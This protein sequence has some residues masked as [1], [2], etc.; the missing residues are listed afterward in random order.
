MVPTILV[1]P[2]WMNSGP[3]HWQSLW[4]RS[5]PTYQRV[6]QRDWN[7]PVRSEW[8]DGLD[9]AVARASAPVVFVAHS[10]GCVAVAAWAEAAFEAAR[11]HVGGAFLVAPADVDRPDVVAELRSWRPLP[12]A[13]LPFPSVI[14]ASHTDEYV[15]FSQARAMAERWHS[16]LVDAGEAGHLNTAAG[17][18]PWPEGHRLLGDLIERVTQVR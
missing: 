17:Y 11:Q 12:R 10:L 5:H 8:V 7:N 16:D 13:R 9:R 1:V 15:E 2:G 4:E 18:G 14:V 3:E 6:A